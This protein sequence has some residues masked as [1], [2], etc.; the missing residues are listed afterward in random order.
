MTSLVAEHDRKSASAAA[1]RF[2][3]QAPA[4]VSFAV[5]DLP[6]GRV[7]AASTPKGLARIAYE[8]LNGTVDQIVQQLADRLS[9]RI[10]EQP[11]KLDRVARE[12]DEYF[13][14]KRAQFDLTLDWSLIRGRFAAEVLKAT[15]AIPYGHTSSYGQIAALAGNAAAS[16]ATGNALGNNP[17]PVVIPCHRVLR[18]GGGMG[19]YTGGVERKQSLLA[20]ESGGPKALYQL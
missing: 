17:I 6:I 11:A 4:D 10:L 16:R 1:D 18:T 3:A 15:I 12:L 8:D 5:L 20:L 7:V 14:G 13:A 9:P 2:A 19:G